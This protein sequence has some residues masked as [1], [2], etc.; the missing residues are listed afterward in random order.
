M[1]DVPVDRRVNTLVALG[2]LDC[3]V[4]TLVWC[5]E[6][7][8]A[9]MAVPGDSDP[10]DGDVDGPEDLLTPIIWRPVGILVRTAQASTLTFAGAGVEAVVDDGEA[11]ITIPA[12]E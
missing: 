1:A 2:L 12:P 9:Y 7:D 3:V 4:T 8:R 11:T 10:L 5:D 6:T